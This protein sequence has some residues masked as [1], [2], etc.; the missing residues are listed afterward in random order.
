[1]NAYDY[2]II[3]N[4]SFFTDA[5]LWTKNAKIL[6]EEL[7]GRKNTAATGPAGKRV[8]LAGSPLIFPNYKLLDI[9]ESA[10]CHVSAELTCSSYGR[11]Y[12]PAVIDEETESGIIRALCLK[13][14][15]ASM[16]PCFIG[17]KKLADRA[18]ENVMEHAL[19]GVIYH[20]LRLCQ[21]F[22]MQTVFLRQRMKDSGIPFLSVKTD[23]SSEDTGQL[24][25]RIEAFL[26]MMG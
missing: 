2:F 25:T 3:G 5:A 12:D 26:E 22:D 10:G 23:L 15:S 6:Y 21:V 1:M 7:K 16:C 4:T 20:T 17:M 18:R 13:Y 24:K 11:L 8:L 14:V 19:D 9:L